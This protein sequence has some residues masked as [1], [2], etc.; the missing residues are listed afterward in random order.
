LPATATQDPLLGGAVGRPT[1]TVAPAPPR[2]EQLSGAAPAAGPAADASTTSNVKTDGAPSKPVNVTLMAPAETLSPSN[3]S[4]AMQ[5]NAKLA[6][7]SAAGTAQG[8]WQTAGAQSGL[9][10][11]FQRLQQ[12][13]V[14]EQRLELRGGQWTF[15]CDLPNPQYPQQ[16]RRF[17]GCDATPLGA[18]RGVLDRIEMQNRQ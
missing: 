13:N 11:A 16:K 14:L 5:S 1:S 18:V 10:Q 6:S 8:Q 3:A 7:T 15:T 2:H 17:E 9:E 4:L 12:L